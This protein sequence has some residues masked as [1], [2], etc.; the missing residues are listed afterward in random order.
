MIQAEWNLV[1]A[2][3]CGFTAQLWPGREPVDD[4][5]LMRMTRE[6]LTFHLVVAHGVPQELARDVAG[7]ALRQ[8]EVSVRR[9]T[10]E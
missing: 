2:C 3:R 7:D 9:P 10:V 1:V 4:G 6:I 5:H 8:A